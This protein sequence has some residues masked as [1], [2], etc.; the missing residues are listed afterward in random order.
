MEAI[1]PNRFVPSGVDAQTWIG[2][3]ARIQERRYKAL[4]ETIKIAIAAR[5][6]IGARLALEELR[7]LRP[8]ASELPDL[9]ARVALLP[10]GSEATASASFLWTRGLGAVA[11]FVLGVGLV[12]GLESFRP[13][14]EAPAAIPAAPPVVSTIDAPAADF[15]SPAP[16]ISGTTDA[17]P[18]AAADSALIS[19]ELKGEEPVG[20]AGV[21]TPSPVDGRA[22]DTPNRSTF[23]TAE[24]IEGVIPA[25]GE[26]PDEYVAPGPRSEGRPG[27]AE[28]T[29]ASSPIAASVVRQPLSITQPPPPVLPAA[30]TTANLAAATTTVAPRVDAAAALRASND[31]V[32]QVLNQYAR[33]YGELNPGAARAVWP[34][35]DERALSRAFASLES[36]DVSF[37]NCSIDV[38]GAT[39]S[40]S[41]RGRASYVGKV[42]NRQPRTEARQWNFELTLQGEDWKIA[43]ADVR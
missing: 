31:R 26:I 40:A 34:T 21:R 23:R 36:Q 33:A 2:F 35:V 27:Y 37:D 6:G 13:G 4:L 17:S 30:N 7:E 9:A 29:A 18:V 5:D 11:T 10:T 14:A 1:P 16:A 12:V 24:T 42:G 25:G 8:T 43:K 41:C 19:R 15:A 28:V 3:E 20:T 22:T 32:A 39:A 38:K